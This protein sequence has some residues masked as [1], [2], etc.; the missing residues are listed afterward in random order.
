M[1]IEIERRF[2]VNNPQA[3]LAAPGMISSYEL[4]QGYL[5][6]VNTL[7]VRVRTISDAD[8]NRSAVL[9]LKSPRRG[10]CRQEIEC[11]LG[12]DQAETILASLPP[13]RT[14][15]KRR[16]HIRH[17]DGLVWSVDCFEGLNAGLVIAEVELVHP[18]QRFELPC[19]VGEEITFDRRY[20]NSTLARYPLSNR[21]YISSPHPDADE[22]QTD[23]S[24]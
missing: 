23:R 8:G 2:L 21:I 22:Q 1:A 12:L 11:R 19:W 7:R 13:S 24:R 18:E 15:C 16:H 14:I 4:R 17:R 9:T 10:A 20:G 5:G 3:A 6:V